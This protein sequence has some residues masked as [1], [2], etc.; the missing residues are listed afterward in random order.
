MTT[1]EDRVKYSQRL[2]RDFQHKE[3]QTPLQYFNQMHVIYL[4]HIYTIFATCFGCHT[5]SAGRP[6]DLLK[7]VFFLQGCCF[8][9]IG[10]VIEFK[11]HNS[12]DL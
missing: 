5:P 4:M 8:R 1:K 9:Y 12:V 10:Y 2:E 11:I 6:Y 3:S 7:T